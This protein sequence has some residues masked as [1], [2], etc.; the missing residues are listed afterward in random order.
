MRKGVTD[1]DATQWVGAFTISGKRVE[2]AC[3]IENTAY[4]VQVR[5]SDGTVDNYT[6][7]GFAYYSKPHS[8]SNITLKPKKTTN[9]EIRQARSL[10]DK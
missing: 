6:I 1:F 7:D 10:H 2:S 9:K 3:L 4:P 5:L 8:I